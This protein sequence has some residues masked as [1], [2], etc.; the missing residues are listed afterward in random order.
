M[1]KV[2]IVLVV[3]AV[4]VITYGFVAIGKNNTKL[5]EGIEIGQT[6][7]EIDGFNPDSK[8][9][10]LSSLRGNIVLVDFWASWC[11]PCRRENPNVVAT[12]NKYKNMKFTGAKEFTIFSVS[13]DRD[14]THW[15]GA[16]A[17]D[18]LSWP[19]HVCDFGAW[20]SRLSA[21]YQVNSIPNNFLLDANGVIIAK[22]LREDALGA[23]LD[24]LVQK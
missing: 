20:Q 19:Y 11:G 5:G 1:K 12:Y 21:P 15:K 10:K 8:E 16:I 9:L 23:E 13:L 7:P 22:G 4:A 17:S 14:T 2:N 24:K 6:A 18:N 3:I